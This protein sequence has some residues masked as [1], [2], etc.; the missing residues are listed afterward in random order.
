MLAAGV[1]LKSDAVPGGLQ[2]AAQALSK[3]K[4]FLS[5][6]FVNLTK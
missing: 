5:D 2:A 3:C 6:V 1:L 4:L